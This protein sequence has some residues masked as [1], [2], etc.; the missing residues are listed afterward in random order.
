MFNAWVSTHFDPLSKNKYLIKIQFIT[1]KLT[2]QAIVTCV[3][4]VLKMHKSNTKA[5][6]L[7][8]LPQY[9]LTISSVIVGHSGL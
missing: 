7:R 3:K 6:N 4:S 1:W 2:I 9:K 8:T 5:Y